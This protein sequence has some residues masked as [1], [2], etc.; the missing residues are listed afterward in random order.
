MFATEVLKIASYKEKKRWH[1]AF[2]CSV[3]CD[4]AF[5][6]A[7]IKV[8]TT[9]SKPFLLISQI[10]LRSPR[11]PRVATPHDVK[12]LEHLR[13]PGLLC[14][15]LLL[16]YFLMI[17]S[18]SKMKIICNYIYKKGYNFVTQQNPVRTTLSSGAAVCV[19]RPKAAGVAYTMI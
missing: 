17:L 6:E 12:V 5:N 16:L 15:Y 10:C 14:L 8:F 2:G 11:R 1:E 18:L 4:Q 19:P 13:P 9:S 3:L 7:S